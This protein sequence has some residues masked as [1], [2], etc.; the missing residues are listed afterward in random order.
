MSCEIQC[1]SVSLQEL[2]SLEAKADELGPLAVEAND[3]GKSR[4]QPGPL[5]KE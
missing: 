4:C 1:S 3:E 2:E 5:V